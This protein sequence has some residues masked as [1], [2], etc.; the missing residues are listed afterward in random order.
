M[1]IQ[2]RSGAGRLWIEVDDDGVGI[3]DG[4]LK[5]N[6]SLGLV[7][8]RERFAT[9]GGGLTIQK[10]EPRGT[11]VVVFIPEPPNEAI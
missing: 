3:D 1:D 2:L 9:L 10:R 11:R 7:G 5:K 4:A 6:G 8:I